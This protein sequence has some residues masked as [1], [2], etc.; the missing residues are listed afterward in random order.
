[1]RAAAVGAACFHSYATV[2]AGPEDASE[3]EIRTAKNYVA[4]GN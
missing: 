3:G 2:P 1:M 4:G